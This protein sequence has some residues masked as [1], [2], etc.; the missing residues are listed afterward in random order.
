VAPV[1]SDLF[2]T[3]FLSPPTSPSLRRSVA[4]SLL[5]SFAPFPLLLFPQPP[6][7]PLCSSIM[8]R[9]GPS[10]QLRHSLVTSQPATADYSLIVLGSSVAMCSN[11]DDQSPML[12]WRKS[13]TLG[14]QGES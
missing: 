12:G 6:P 4:P 14:Y 3:R 5:C 9:C 1:L 11:T 7:L 10:S 8:T 13:R 2:P